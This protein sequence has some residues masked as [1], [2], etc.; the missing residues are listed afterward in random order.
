MFSSYVMGLM[1]FFFLK[2]ICKQFENKSMNL[3]LNFS[4]YQKSGIPEKEGKVASLSK[5]SISHYLYIMYYAF[6]S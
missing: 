6:S 2:W 1:Y 3:I 5:K 4:F